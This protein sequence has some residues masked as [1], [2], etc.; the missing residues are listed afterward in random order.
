MARR[1]DI[2]FLTVFS[3]GTPLPDLTVGQA[4]T[5]QLDHGLPLL[6]Q[7]G[8]G[9]AGSWFLTRAA[10]YFADHRITRIERVTTDNTPGPTRT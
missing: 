6:G 2:R 1:W 5:D 10:A 9:P 7:L 4:F 3:A 8:E